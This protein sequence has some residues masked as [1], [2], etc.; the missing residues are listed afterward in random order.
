MEEV[1]KKRSPAEEEKWSRHWEHASSGGQT[2]REAPCHCMWHR[3]RVTTG[4]ERRMRTGILGSTAGEG[5]HRPKP[6]V[7]NMG[8]GRTNCA[9][10]S[11]AGNEKTNLILGRPRATKVTPR[12]NANN[13]SVVARI[14]P[15]KR[16]PCAW[17]GSAR[18]KKCT[19][20]KNCMR[21]SKR[22][23][24]EWKHAQECQGVSKKRG[25]RPTCVQQR[26]CD[27]KKRP[28]LTSHA[29]GARNKGL[30]SWETKKPLECQEQHRST[31]CRRKKAGGNRRE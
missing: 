25:P 28:Q 11:D 1:V 2:E 27:E 19:I 13:K 4:E 12:T 23:S 21:E 15:P 17:T 30:L 31:T 22:E 20:E 14:I 5:R 10:I 6:F 16:L 3:S 9:E 24:P 7:P 26:N 18:V 29:H 8:F